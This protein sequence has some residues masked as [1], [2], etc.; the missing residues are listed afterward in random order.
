MKRRFVLQRFRCG[1]E[2]FLTVDLTD[3][4]DTGR[5]VS[6]RETVW[7]GDDRMP[8][9][10]RQWVDRTPRCDDDVHVFEYSCRFLHQ[11]S[12]DAVRLQVLDGRHEVRR[13]ELATVTLPAEEISVASSA[14]DEK[15]SC[16]TYDCFSRDSLYQ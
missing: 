4:R 12:A 7:D 3:E 5:R 1:Q 11:Q 14:L 16:I 9:H 8:G 6:V 10:A 13:A 2:L 15:T